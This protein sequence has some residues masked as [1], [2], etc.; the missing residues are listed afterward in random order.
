MAMTDEQALSRP[1]G[2]W[3]KEADSRLD[4]AFDRQLQ[5]RNVDRRDWQVLASLARR[6]TGRTE[7]IDSLAAFDTP[8]VLERVVRNLESRGWVE[9]CNGLLRLTSEGVRE[10][11][12]L[13]P[14][15]DQ[16]RRQVAEALPQDDY[17]ALVRLLGR[18]ISGLG[19]A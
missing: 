9:D 12:A 14:L 13:L 19:A 10:Q 1:I 2:W 17:V 7:L 6:P 5:R 3:L 15:V 18:L 4:A 11:A 8:E 16:V